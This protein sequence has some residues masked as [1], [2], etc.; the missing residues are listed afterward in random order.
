MIIELLFCCIISL[1]VYVNRD[2]IM[3]KT[4]GLVP[5]G[6]FA[7]MMKQWLNLQIY[8]ALL[9]ALGAMLLSVSV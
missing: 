2:K 9:F 8:F 6:T 4:F 1:M 7:Q 3:T 5:N